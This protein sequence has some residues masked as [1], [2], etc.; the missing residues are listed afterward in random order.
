M[1]LKIP[2][3]HFMLL[4]PFAPLRCHWMKPVGPHCWQEEHETL[5]GV[6]WV[7]TRVCGKVCT[8]MDYRNSVCVSTKTPASPAL[9]LYLSVAN[10]V[11]RHKTI[12][13]ITLTGR[14]CE[15]FRTRAYLHN[16]AAELLF[17]ASNNRGI[18]GRMCACLVFMLQSKRKR[19]LPATQQRTW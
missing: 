14:E 15:N 6:L 12:S 18:T 3:L 13:Q 17:N 9:Y 1:R 5:G 19:T 11:K 8:Y 10:I 4:C 16:W 7:V 2:T